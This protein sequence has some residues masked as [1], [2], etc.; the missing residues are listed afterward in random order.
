[1]DPI[2]STVIVLTVGVGVLWVLRRRTIP[3]TSTSDA[4][5]HYFL[6]RDHLETLARIAA[7]CGTVPVHT[8]WIRYVP[9]RNGS[10]G[11][12]IV[13]APVHGADDP[14]MRYPKSAVPYDVSS[15]YTATVA[16]VIASKETVYLATGQGAAHDTPYS[17]DD[18][19]TPST[20]GLSMT[21]VRDHPSFGVLPVVHYWHV[22]PA[23]WSP[24]LR[25]RYTAA[26]SAFAKDL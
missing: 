3:D 18:E 14:A 4:I 13:L 20:V 5:R 19:A 1:M 9:P 23:A 12:R 21:Y 16:D 10:A 7:E 15:A 8:E 22:Q 6:I 24:D 11:T 17:K 2:V 25:A 26:I